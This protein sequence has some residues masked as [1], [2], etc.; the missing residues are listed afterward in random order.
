MLTILQGHNIEVMRGL[1]AGSVHLIVTSPPYWGLRDY[2]IPP[3]IWGGVAD[4]AHEWGEAIMTPWA[5]G[6]SGLNGANKNGPHSRHQAKETGPFC[7]KCNA[8]RGVFGLE[9]TPE[10]YVEHSVMIFRE[11]KRVLR[12]DGTLWVNLGDSYC[13]SAPGS[14]GDGLHQRGI[15]AGVSDRRAEAAKKPRP[16]T[17]SGLGPGD[18][19][20]IPWRVA[21][22]LQAD[23]WTLRRDNIWFKDNPMPESV[24]GWRWEKHRVKVRDSERADPRHSHTLASGGVLKPHAARDGASFADQSDKYVDC[25]GCEKCTPNGGLILRKGN[26]R[27]TTSHEYVFQFS[28]SDSYYCDAEAAREKSEYVPRRGISPVSR[29]GT[30]RNDSSR[31]TGDLGSSGNRNKR[32]VWQ[33]P[34][35][36]YRD[37]HFAT[38]PPAL[39]R[40]IIE[41]ATSIKCCA[42]CEAPWAPVIERGEP[43]MEHRLASGSD[44]E[45]EYHPTGNGKYYEDSRV[46]NS[47]T[48]KQRILAGMVEKKIVD[49]RPSCDCGV[50][51]T[52]PAVVLDMHGGSGTLGQVALQLGR[53]AILIDLNT[54]YIKMMEKRTSV[55]LGLALG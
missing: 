47:R 19:V 5:N 25:T 18:L 36:P 31:Q 46:E 1:P 2:K 34:T 43:D 17:P 13:S 20:G 29:N 21:F 26:W 32:S 53:R 40:P 16:E 27:C 49:W 22:A 33:I 15:L 44:E 50:S 14:M 7:K 8:W 37:A 30:G 54:D 48:V 41:A 3:C 55:N 6:V 28:K 23:G 52:V 35:A 4:C 12:D 51:E 42:K 10:L 39:V 11:A 24:N 9:P 45:G 38:F